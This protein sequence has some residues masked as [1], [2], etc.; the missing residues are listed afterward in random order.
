MKKLVTGILMVSGIVLM[1]ENTYLTNLKKTKDKAIKRIEDQ[2]VIKLQ[3]LMQTLT[4]KGDLDGAMEVKAEIARMKGEKIEDQGA[5]EGD[6]DKNKYTLP[7][8]PK[9]WDSIKGITKKLDLQSTFA[10]PTK[11]YRLKKG[12]KVRIVPHPLDEWGT[13]GKFKW[14]GSNCYLLFKIDGVTDWIKPQ[15]LKNDN[16]IIEAPDSGYLV[17]LSVINGFGKLSQ[18]GNIR[19]KIVNIK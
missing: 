7:K 4:R 18:K 6:A 2:Y 3:A 14:D 13:R 16:M 12:Q 15:E 19:V 11:L 10:K 5:S 1:G 17:T 8:T 9:E